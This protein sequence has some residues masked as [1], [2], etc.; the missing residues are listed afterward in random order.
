M[1]EERIADKALVKADPEVVKGGNLDME[2][3]A[4]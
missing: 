1:L 4:R 2:E 3:V